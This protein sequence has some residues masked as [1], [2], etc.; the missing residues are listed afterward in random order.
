MPQQRPPSQTRLLPF[1]DL[2]A[3]V[4]EPR[5]LDFCHASETADRES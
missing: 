2:F 1:T 5:F 4:P 3:D